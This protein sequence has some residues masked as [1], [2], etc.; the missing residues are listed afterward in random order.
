VINE[1]L[2]SGDAEI[3]KIEIM[4]KFSFFEIEDKKEQ[5][6]IKSLKGQ[7]FEGIPLL[8]E[9]SQEKPA[10]AYTSRE[11]PYKR[12]D[13]RNKKSGGSGRREKR[14]SGDTYRKGKKR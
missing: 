14:K 1:G 4:K 13:Y 2:N 5:Q 10:G 8:C 11:K 3:G 12:K 9:V 7:E 6:L